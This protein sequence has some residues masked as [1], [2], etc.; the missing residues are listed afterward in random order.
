[1]KTYPALM[2]VI[3]LLLSSSLPAAQ[4]PDIKF[5]VKY[6]GG[7]FPLAHE[8]VDVHVGN[9]T[10]VL[11]QDGKRFVVPIAQITQVAYGHVPNTGL[12]Q[13]AIVW[14][15]PTPPANGQMVLVVENADYDRFVKILQQLLEKASLTRVDQTG[16]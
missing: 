10:V 6:D 7:T 9:D 8:T 4:A 12:G 16:K 5:A 13:A 2:S 1:M 11:I 15:A 14:A 3:V